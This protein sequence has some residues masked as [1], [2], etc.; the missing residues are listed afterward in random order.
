M[1]RYWV[2]FFV[3]VLFLTGC[4][5][6][7][8]NYAMESVA[9]EEAGA[10]PMMELAAEAPMEWSDEAVSSSSVEAAT[11]ERLVIKNAELRIIVDDPA[12]KMEALS[13]LA[14]SLGGYV[15]SSRTYEAYVRGDLYV[16]EGEIKLRIPSERLDEA[17][18]MV[19]ADVQEVKNE[20]VWGEDVTDQYVDLQSRLKAKKAAEEKMVEILAQAKNTE[21]TLAVYAEL[22]RIQSDIEVLT[23]QI[24]YYEKSAAMSSVTI[25]VVASEKVKPIEIGG[26]KLGETASESV[27][28][29]IDYLQGFTRFLIRFVIVILP[30][31]ITWA[32]PLYFVF[33]GVRALM[34]K[35]KEK[36]AQKAAE[37]QKE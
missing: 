28:D 14:T 23:G 9:Y 34:R 29:L 4:G 7:S 6:S 30:V 17:L 37:K 5:A 24:N 12:V 3:A 33:K 22:Q 36:K 19:K 10:A 26:W 1:K 16:P 21:D 2:I 13:T 20:S 11:Q 15:V 31:L 27:Q 25:Y 35:R 18:E 8:A 32:I